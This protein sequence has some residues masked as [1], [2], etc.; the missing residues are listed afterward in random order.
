MCNFLTKFQFDPL[1]IKIKIGQKL[2][3]AGVLPGMAGMNAIPVG[4]MP[5]QF[6]GAPIQNLA[7]AGVLVPNILKPSPTMFSGMGITN[8]PIQQKIDPALKKIFVRN[9][10]ED[11]PDSFMESLLKV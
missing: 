6:V 7:M 1:S 5:N 9:I 10:P 8:L 2:P 4:L 11:V 3:Q